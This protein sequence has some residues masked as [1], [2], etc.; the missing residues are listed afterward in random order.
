GKLNRLV[1]PKHF[2]ERHFLPQMLGDG[3]PGRV[4]GAVLRF[5]DGRGGGKAWEFRFS[6]WGSSQSYVMT[7]GWSAFLRDRRRHRLLL[8]RRREPLHR[9]PPARRR[10]S[11]L[12]AGDTR[13]CA[14]SSA[15][16][17]RAHAAA[18]DVGRQGFARAVPPA[19]RRRPR[20]FHCRAAA[21]GFA[22]SPHEEM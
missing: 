15:A 8:P 9:L 16:S 17:L 6:Y 4:A 2:A 13:P 18:G 22:A 12:S 11:V 1:V 3:G 5:E 19:V 20:A 14:C 7:K 21:V 10:S